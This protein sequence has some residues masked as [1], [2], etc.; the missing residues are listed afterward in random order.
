MPNTRQIKIIIA[1][2]KKS[3]RDF[4]I[5]ILNKSKEFTVAGSVTAAASLIH[6]LGEHKP[7]IIL[8]E[9]NLQKS[10]GVD[11]TKIIHSMRPDLGIIGLINGKE[12]NQFIEMIQAGAKGLIYHHRLKNELIPAITSVSNNRL[13]FCSGTVEKIYHYILTSVVQIPRKVKLPQ[14]AIPTDRFTMKEIAIIK[15]ICQENTN[16]EIAD[17]FGL[18][19]RSVEGYRENILLK[20]KAKNTAGIV[21]FAIRN[22]IFN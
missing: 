5:N 1:T 13:Y 20:M 22:N 4:L 21:V 8:T 16:K 18:S 10:S 19:K 6:L 17:V 12:K 2:Q 11:V 15:L 3:K 14:Q 7:D 9:P